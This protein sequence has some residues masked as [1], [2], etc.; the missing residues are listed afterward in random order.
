MCLNE[1][2]KVLLLLL[3]L[4]TTAAIG[5]C[6]KQKKKKKEKK[7]EKGK[8]IQTQISAYLGELTLFPE[9]FSRQVEI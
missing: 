8:S 6:G 3:L 1:E 9:Q 5:G 2:A 7:Q 4:L